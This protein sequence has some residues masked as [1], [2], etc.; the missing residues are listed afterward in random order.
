MWAW[1]NDVAM[2]EPIEITRV[3]GSIRALAVAEQRAFLATDR[4]GWRVDLATGVAEA[5]T[6]AAD[7]VAIS[8]DGRVALFVGSRL[9]AVFVDVASGRRVQS[10]QLADGVTSAAWS[11]DRRAVALAT[12]WGVLVVDGVSLAIAQKHDL[13]GRPQRVWIDDA[14]NVVAEVG[15]ARYAIELGS[16][17]S[18][19]AGE[20][21]PVPVAA[22]RC[23][24]AEVAAIRLAGC[25]D[26][27]L[28]RLF[29]GD[30]L[31]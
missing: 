25:E 16:G 28:Y 22:A 20:A 13:G 8:P 26:G 21:E 4:A 10:I 6:E 23:V 18:K 24:V 7:S 2:A 5:V 19:Q 11:A 15:A 9:G 31:P 17:Q 12:R 27:V 14:L 1:V 30:S 29:E 3:E